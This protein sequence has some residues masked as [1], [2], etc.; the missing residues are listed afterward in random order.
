MPV[1]PFDV[2]DENGVRVT[3]TVEAYRDRNGPY[4]DPTSKFY[5]NPRFSQRDIQYLNTRDVCRINPAV[6]SAAVQDV[7][8]KALTNF[9]MDDPSP[10]AIKDDI[11]NSI[12]ETLRQ[13]A[14][15]PDKYV[16]NPT[17]SSG[18]APFSDT[19]APLVPIVHSSGFL[20]SDNDPVK[21]RSSIRRLS[22]P[23][24]GIIAR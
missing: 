14:L 17:S 20:A 3:G 11:N 21:E 24:L 12:A 8:H 15:H 6:L 9:G 10:S 18:W 2:T 13:C 19:G 16:S 23:V 7:F 4:Y 1:E 22:S 5:Q